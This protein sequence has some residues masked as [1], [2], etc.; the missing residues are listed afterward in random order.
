MASAGARWITR[1]KRAI[2][3]FWISWNVLA[4]LQEGPGRAWDPEKGPGKGDKVRRDKPTRKRTRKSCHVGIEILYLGAHRDPIRPRRFLKKAQ[5]D[6]SR[7][8]RAISVGEDEL[9]RAVLANLVYTGLGPQAALSGVQPP[10]E[11]HT[12]LRHWHRP[13][14]APRPG[15]GI[16]VNGLIGSS[17][18]TRP[19][20][21]LHFRSDSVSHR[22][23]LRRC[24]AWRLRDDRGAECQGL[25]RYRRRCRGLWARKRG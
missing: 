23:P 15:T 3:G 1:A 12:F 16:G 6:A 21:S 7:R 25:F 14:I 5:V 4:P 10:T 17:W 19:R 9:Q 8:S 24:A 11:R 2:R 18:Q 13:R 22:W 20:Q